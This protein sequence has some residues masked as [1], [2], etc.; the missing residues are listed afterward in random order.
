MVRFIDGLKTGVLGGLG[1]AGIGRKWD[2]GSGF[3]VRFEPGKPCNG[4]YPRMFRDSDGNL[5]KVTGPGWIPCDL[6]G[7]L[8]TFFEG[9]DPNFGNAEWGSGYAAQ[10]L[11][12]S[13]AIFHQ[14]ESWNVWVA[15]CPEDCAGGVPP[16]APSWQQLFAVAAY[17]LGASGNLP[18]VD[19][20]PFSRVRFVINVPGGA[21]AADII[22]QG[23]EAGAGAQGG[24]FSVGATGIEPIYT[25]GFQSGKTTVIDLIELPA[26]NAGAG[27]IVAGAGQTQADI[28]IIAPKIF[29]AVYIGTSV[30]QTVNPFV[31]GY[32]WTGS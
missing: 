5:H 26:L 7:G 14:P 25:A 32:G 19:I 10:G 1:L 22:V 24:Y 15:D 29:S 12:A 16:R 27:S 9:T 31:S 21:T 2:V 8:I 23:L 28:H 3:A 4:S 18:I 13:N 20:R 30:A 6:R 17:D 11:T